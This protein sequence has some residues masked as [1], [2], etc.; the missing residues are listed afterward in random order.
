MAK[1]PKKL[2]T[3]A[4]RTL[5]CPLSVRSPRR[6][7]TDRGLTA[8]VVLERLSLVAKANQPAG[9]GEPNKRVPGRSSCC[10]STAETTKSLK[11]SNPTS[12][13]R[14]IESTEA[15]SAK[16]TSVVKKH[17]GTVRRAAK[18]A[19]TNESPDRLLTPR[20]LNERIV[21]SSPVPSRKPG[22][23][24]DNGFQRVLWSKHFVAVSNNTVD[25][26][27][28]DSAKSNRHCNI[29]FGNDCA[30]L[31]GR[32]EYPRRPFAAPLRT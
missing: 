16:T 29:V 14:R 23:Y 13:Q 5:G 3:T 1:R 7:R 2:R 4:V 18:T 20:P 32:T 10:P 17:A 9:E 25:A 26:V 28:H 21:Q 27:Q 19:T 15:N 22:P 6:N 12:I 30:C 24:S 11:A 8:S 31:K